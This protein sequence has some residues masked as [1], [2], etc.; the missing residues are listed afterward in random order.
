MINGMNSLSYK[1]EN[2]LIRKHINLKCPLSYG[3][4]VVGEKLICSLWRISMYPVAIHICIDDLKNGNINSYAN[5]HFRISQNNF[6]KNIFV[7]RL[8]YI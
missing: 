5:V 8:M 3:N 2:I 4:L 7:D 1:T 6:G